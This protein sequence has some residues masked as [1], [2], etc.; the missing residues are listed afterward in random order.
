MINYLM[1]DI[2]FL[3]MII[4]VICSCLIM[5]KMFLCTSASVLLSK[6]E[7]ASSSIRSFGDLMRARAIANR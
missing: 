7:V 2:S 5:S 6:A 4:A 3:P 1:I